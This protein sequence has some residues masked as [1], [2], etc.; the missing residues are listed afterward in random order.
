MSPD[1]LS[2]LEVFINEPSNKINK[3][4]QDPDTGIILNSEL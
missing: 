3:T 2:E 4:V 1:E